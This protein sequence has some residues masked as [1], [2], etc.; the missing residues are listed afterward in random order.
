MIFQTCFFWSQADVR[1][2]GQDLFAEQIVFFLLPWFVQ[3]AGGFRRAPVHIMD[4]K[5]AICSHRTGRWGTFS[6]SCSSRRGAN[7]PFPTAFICTTRCRIPCISRTWKMGFDG[8]RGRTLFFFFFTLVTGPRRAL[9]LKLSDT[10]VYEPEIRTRLGR[11]C[12][13]WGASWARCSS[14]RPS[15]PASTPPIR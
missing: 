9:S 7:R 5:K 13:R 1:A 11:T 10:R 6:P 8:A 2:C 4:L 3:P 14:A 12:G 15:S